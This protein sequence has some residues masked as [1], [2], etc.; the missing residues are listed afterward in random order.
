MTAITA[1]R[2]DEHRREDF[3]RLHSDANGAGWCRCVAWWVP[4]WEGWASALRQKTPRS[5]RP[6]ATPAS[7]TVSWPTTAASRSAGARPARATD[8]RSSAPSSVSTP[9]RRSGRSPASSSPLPTAAEASRALLRHAL[10]DLGARGVT[11]VEAYPREGT[12]LGE[13]DIWD[14]P[15]PALLCG[16]LHARG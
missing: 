12:D 8:W 6:S 15:R 5:G 16:G 10:A 1:V 13:D 7:T 3:R 11:R 9:T 14:G 2:F 4:T